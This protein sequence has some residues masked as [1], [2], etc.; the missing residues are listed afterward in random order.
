MTTSPPVNARLRSGECWDLLH[1][2]GIGVLATSAAGRPDLFPVTYLVDGGA[3]MFRTAPG[4]KVEQL[5][6]NDNAAFIV[7]G[8]DGDGHW[9]VV[10]RGT[11]DIMD[12]QVEIV[13]SGALELA[14]WAP[15]AKHL[16]LRLTPSRV[17]GRRIQRADLARADLYG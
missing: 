1:R 2:S 5:E 15:G 7:Q 17:T 3:L 6:E 8:H 11:V 12:D 16:F 10:L 14:A 4:T 9:S 13:G